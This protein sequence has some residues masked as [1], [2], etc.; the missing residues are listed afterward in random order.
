MT[1]MQEA[2]DALVEKLK[3]SIKK[4]HAQNNADTHSNTL[5]EQVLMKFIYTHLGKG[6]ALA[7][8]SLVDAHEALEKGD[9]KYDYGYVEC[10]QCDYPDTKGTWHGQVHLDPY[11][12]RH[13]NPLAS[14]WLGAAQ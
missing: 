14:S 13:H 7:A 3:N 9:P 12:N 2:Y 4:A 1:H 10:V 8:A 5:R 11:R 6:G